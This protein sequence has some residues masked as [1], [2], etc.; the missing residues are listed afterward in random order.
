MNEY[1]NILNFYLDGK[2]IYIKLVRL[3]SLLF[4]ICISS[5][6][7]KYFIEDYTFLEI[8]DYQGMLLFLFNGNFVVPMTIFA[9]IFFVTEIPGRLLKLKELLETEQPG[10]LRST[11]L[12][13]L[14]RVLTYVKDEVNDRDGHENQDW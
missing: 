9:I 5:Y 7:Y 4:I 13:V 11:F 8:N 6:L 10:Y 14:E 12:P 1:L 3:F 2:P